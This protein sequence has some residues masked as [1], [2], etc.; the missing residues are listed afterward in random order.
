VS[1]DSAP[2][3]RHAVNV[4]SFDLGE[5]P[6]QANDLRTAKLIRTEPIIQGM[7]SSCLSFVRHLSDQGGSLVT[8]RGR[9]ARRA[10][11]CR[12]H[13]TLEFLYVV[14]LG[15]FKSIGNDLHGEQHVDGFH[16]TGI[17]WA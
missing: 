2:G 12:E 6:G 4:F 5:E 3:D 15:H 9:V 8:G 10:R 14:R 13:D 17:G 11:L 1:L 16:M 7:R